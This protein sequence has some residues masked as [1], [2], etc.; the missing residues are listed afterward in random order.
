VASTMTDLAVPTWVLSTPEGRAERLDYPYGWK[1]LNQ[2]LMRPRRPDVAEHVADPAEPWLLLPTPDRTGEPVLLEVPWARMSL[3]RAVPE[4]L[5]YRP[6]D[7]VYTGLAL[8]EGNAIAL[9]LVP[10]L[11]GAAD[12]SI[13]SR[14][15]TKSRLWRI[16]IDYGATTWASVADVARAIYALPSSEEDRAHAVRLVTS[17]G[18]PPQIWRAFEKRYG[19]SVVE[20]SCQALGNSSAVTRQPRRALTIC[21]QV[22][23]AVLSPGPPSQ[24]S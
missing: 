9:A 16:C 15:F 24:T 6:D 19:V 2:V 12:R 3:L 10:P 7:V 22:E 11:V 23:S 5:G 4:A 8:T 17:S 18:M 13:I 20:W 21:S 14:R 1:C